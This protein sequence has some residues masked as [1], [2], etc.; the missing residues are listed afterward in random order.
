MGGVSLLTSE[1]AVCLCVCV[2][3]FV[4]EW[5]Q[6]SIPAKKKKIFV[7]LK[8]EKEKGGGKKGGTQLFKSFEFGN[9]SRM[10][11][12]KPVLLEFKYLQNKKW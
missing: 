3:V 9:G 10:H 11:N 2:C 5:Y 4:W 12:K 8:F 6:I 1:C 7:R